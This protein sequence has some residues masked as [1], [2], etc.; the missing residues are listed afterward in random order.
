M[1]HRREKRVILENVAAMFVAWTGSILA[2]PG[3]VHGQPPDGQAV[4]ATNPAK[5]RVNY[6]P[7]ASDVWQQY[8]E[9]R[10]LDKANAIAAE[11][12]TSG[13]LSQVVNDLTPSPQ[14][15]PDMAETSASRYYPTSNW[16]SDYNYYVVPGSGYNYGWYGGYNPSYG[17]RSY[18]NYWWN[19]GSSGYGGG[20]GG[21]YWGGGWRRGDGVSTSHRNWNYSHVDRSTHDPYNERHSDNAHHQYHAQHTSA[22]HH[23]PGHHAAARHASNHSADHRG[24]SH[25]R[26]G[27]ART[28]GHHAGGHHAA[29]H[30]SRGHTGKGGRGGGRGGGHH[31]SPGGHAA[32]HHAGHLDP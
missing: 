6:R 31:A 15:F 7:T 21:H 20:W 27:G 18:P 2:A 12:Q 28:A 11:V 29:G 26:A 23:Q 3:G 4:T 13:Y 16:A 1:R 14:P 22:G 9:T 8:A 25:N 17:Y 19:G 10:S 24:N 5:Y 32:S 30:S